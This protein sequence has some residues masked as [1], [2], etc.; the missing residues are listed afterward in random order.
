MS[1]TYITKAFSVQGSWNRVHPAK[2]AVFACD[3]ALTV[4]FRA[5]SKKSVGSLAGSWAWTRP[6][7][8]AFLGAFWQKTEFLRD[9]GFVEKSWRMSPSGRNQSKERPEL[10]GGV[11]FSVWRYS[12]AIASMFA[13]V[14]ASN[15]LLASVG[16]Q[17][18]KINVLSASKLT[19]DFV[20]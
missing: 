17:S 12:L 10:T 14:A 8:S 1:T 16:Y 9:G 11:F 2:G 19:N 7:N 15:C 18:E 4:A 20:S 6:F 13:W 3:P 5:G